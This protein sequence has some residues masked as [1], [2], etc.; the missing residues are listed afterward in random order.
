MKDVTFRRMTKRLVCSLVLVVPDDV[1]PA[2]GAD[3]LSTCVA[4]CP[5]GPSSGR[6]S[7]TVK[8]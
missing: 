5:F 8:R 2:C 4:D 3:A 1:V 6:A 7:S